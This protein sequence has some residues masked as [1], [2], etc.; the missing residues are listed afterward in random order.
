MTADDEEISNHPEPSNHR[1]PI[2]AGQVLLWYAVC[3]SGVYVLLV[4]PHHHVCQSTDRLHT[5]FAEGTL[6]DD[7]TG[8]L[9]VSPPL[10]SRGAAD[11]PRQP[12]R[13]SFLTFLC[14]SS[15]H[16]ELE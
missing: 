1:T 16:H 15:G 10:E 5:L 3:T 4:A 6:T 9:S 2:R 8:P 12:R 11:R 13:L 7:R 14:V